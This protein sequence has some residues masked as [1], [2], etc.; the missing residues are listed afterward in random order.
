M[1][2]SKQKLSEIASLHIK[3]YRKQTGLFLVEGEKIIDELLLSDWKIQFLL[4]N[5][6]YYPKY[7]KKTINV[8]ELDDKH[9]SKLSCLSTPSG[10]LA[11]VHQKEWDSSPSLF[12]NKLSLCLDGIR[13]PGNLGTIIRIAD[14]FGIENI[15]C[16]P[17]TVDLYN[18][19]T[20][21]ATMGSFLRVKICFT[22]LVSFI[23]SIKLLQIPVYGAVLNGKNL[24]TQKLNK[25]GLIVLGSESHG[26]SPN[27]ISEIQYPISIPSG[28]LQS[29]NPNKVSLSP[30]SL[31]VAI[32]TAVICGVFAQ[33]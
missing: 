29:S 27:I 31:N 24:Y 3:K 32:A 9:F 22:E 26:I 12:M 23:K 13:D 25:Q 8:V 19:K 5:K 2:L 1:E 4:V 18:S 21:Q 15:V 14:W 11:V 30:D 33:H 6:E 7:A 20:L 10:I 28:L 16:S 17:D